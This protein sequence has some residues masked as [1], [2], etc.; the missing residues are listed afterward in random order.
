MKHL[1]APLPSRRSTAIVSALVAFVAAFVWLSASTVT[2]RAQSVNT[3]HSLSVTAPDMRQPLG[4]WSVSRHDEQARLMGE[5]G[6]VRSGT[7][8]VQATSQP[9]LDA[10]GLKLRHVGALPSPEDDRIPAV[11]VIWDYHHAIL[12][13]LEGMTPLLPMSP[14][15][16]QSWPAVDL[17]I[18]ELGRPS[19][20]YLKAR[21]EVE[22]AI[23]RELWSV[24][25]RDVLLWVLRQAPTELPSV[26][27][28]DDP[29]RVKPY[30][31]DPAVL[32]ALRLGPGCVTAL[33]AIVASLEQP[34]DPRITA[35]A[36]FLR[37]EL[38]VLDRSI[39]ASLAGLTAN[40]PLSGDNRSRWPEPERAAVERFGLSCH[41]FLENLRSNDGVYAPK[42]DWLARWVRREAATDLVNRLERMAANGTLKENHFEAVATAEEAATRVAG[43]PGGMFG[44]LRAVDD[45]MVFLLTMEYMHIEAKRLDDEAGSLDLA[46]TEESRKAAT[47]KR[48]VSGILTT[49]RNLYGAPFDAVAITDLVKQVRANPPAMDAAFV[50]FRTHELPKLTARSLGVLLAERATAGSMAAKANFLRESV[51]ARD[52]R[53]ATDMFVEASKRTALDAKLPFLDSDFTLLRDHGHIRI[54]REMAERMRF[55][56]EMLQRRVAG[57]YLEVSNGDDG[58]FVYWFRGHPAYR[59][60]IHLSDA[61]FQALGSAEG[62]FIE[63]GVF[64][65]GDPGNDGRAY[66]FQNSVAL[67]G[68]S[69]DFV[70]APL[71]PAMTFDLEHGRTYSFTF[72]YQTRGMDGQFAWIRFIPVDSQNNRIT[73]MA[74][75]LR[76]AGLTE[77]EF[78]PFSFAR[79]NEDGSLDTNRFTGTTGG[80][81]TARFMLSRVP[82]PIAGFNIEIKLADL[83]GDGEAFFRNF[84]LDLKRDWFREDFE[85][86]AYMPPPGAG[87]SLRPDLGAAWSFIQDADRRLMPAYCDLTWQTV[88]L[89]SGSTRALLVEPKGFNFRMESSEPFELRHDR[90]YLFRGNL[91]TENMGTLRAWFEVMLYDSDMR[92]VTADGLRCAHGE[93]VMRTPARG[94]ELRSISLGGLKVPAG[95]MTE[96]LHFDE[97]RM[98]ELAELRGPGSMARADTRPRYDIRFA[99]VAVVVDG[100]DRQYGARIGIDNIEILEY[101]RVTLTLGQQMLDPESSL[102]PGERVWGTPE[103]LN[104]V[105]ARPAPP[106]DPDRFRLF[107]E[108]AVEGL[109]PKRA[110]YHYK[111]TLH[112]YLGNPVTALD[113][114][115]A[116]KL[117]RLVYSDAN[118]S[119]GSEE[120]NRIFLEE[121]DLRNTF[122]YFSASFELRYADQAEPLYQR[123]FLVGF[124]PPSLMGEETR[125]TG[126]YGVVIGHDN[127]RWGRVAMALS[128]LQVGRVAFPLFRTGQ[129]PGAAPYENN[130][131]VT[132]YETLMD[133]LP[134]IRRTAILGPMPV[135]LER[136]SAGSGAA[137]VFAEQGRT[138]W[139]N[140]LRQAHLHWRDRFDEFVAGSIDDESYT[141]FTADPA[142]ALGNLNAE[143][144][145][146]LVDW[147]PRLIPV[148]VDVPGR[149][150]PTLDTLARSF[151]RRWQPALDAQSAAIRDAVAQ[152]LDAPAAQRVREQAPR[153][154]WLQD[155]E[156]FGFHI[157][158]HISP[159]QMQAAVAEILA[160]VGRAG[161]VLGDNPQDAIANAR[162]IAGGGTFDFSQY[163]AELAATSRHTLFIDLVP[164]DPALDTTYAGQLR[165]LTEKLVIAK[166]AGFGRIFISRLHDSGEIPDGLLTRDNR[167]RPAFFAFRT[168]NSVLSGTEMVPLQLSLP[169]GARHQ[170]FR[171]TRTGE[172]TFFIFPG[173][174]DITEDLPFGHGVRQIDL[175]GNPQLL[176]TV[177]DGGTARV[178]L[179]AGGLPVILAGIDI[180]LMETL[181]GVNLE[182]AT[183]QGVEADQPLAVTVTNRFDSPVSAGIR[184]P[185]AAD[186]GDLDNIVNDARFRDP[187]GNEVSDSATEYLFPSVQLAPGQTHTF[188]FGFRPRSSMKIGNRVLP[189]EVN[190]KGQREYSVFRRIPV[191]VS[192]QVTVDQIDLISTTGDQGV[193]DLAMKI[194]NGTARNQAFVATVSLPE[195]SGSWPVTR[196]F[197]VGG[198]ATAD[199]T[200]RLPEFPGAKLEGLL[201]RLSLRQT[202]SNLFYNQDYRVKW[203]GERNS[204]VLLPEQQVR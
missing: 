183:I 195:V 33:D 173:D 186:D 171:N 44:Q 65:R 122:G 50:D 12:A 118:G 140:L 160:L 185:L 95:W 21:W 174:R 148:T 54:D 11:G 123:E 136:L 16:P 82:S 76:A 63:P 18:Y 154:I 179:R 163:A 189:V 181:L 57:G 175:M 130:S 4:G 14:G 105:L 39:T 104:G 178:R 109:T 169:S 37:R 203:D 144:S 165:D 97:L 191:T 42:A 8:R 90:Q 107:I 32:P 5:A 157:P 199:V 2:V 137:K 150:G 87:Q 17:D 9:D 106:Q 19:L 28:A 24:F 61:D 10:N 45:F 73:S 89:P 113:I 149:Q 15:R 139:R 83:T 36:G 167:A 55:D 62:I 134:H 151:S 202:P 176:S 25:E 133:M 129:V 101:P 100:P 197:S 201:V 26:P 6:V 98:G 46:A 7:F 78:V 188:R 41:A 47:A 112:D 124:V 1:P 51:K 103:R 22:Q 69:V 177:G 153:A 108:V 200:R 187:R 96:R 75:E 38:N 56:S 102:V 135:S 194:R 52:Q 182:N 141:G 193:P 126:D 156:Q 74:D 117:D 192:P 64:F 145:K 115:G 67:K 84:R 168:L 143:F 81:E 13:K 162:T 94:D 132:E 79:Y 111:L 166:Q 29:E 164:V 110:G 152:A 72:E 119:I 180:R 184:I 30:D 53:P 48:L 40:F 85:P 121:L 70:P 20:P 116:Q 23:Q 34:V 80:W 147:A 86:S 146:N 88:N 158:A 31:G 3:E 159:Q 66:D 204:Y 99:R 128:M 43:I 77:G 127:N 170:F 71:G 138:E 91:H 92:P 190:I 59:R 172:L 120:F 60:L 142:G 35:W 114:L 131:F 58:G 93:N 198:N 68:L 155:R 49:A 125:T 196:D 161:S 27:N